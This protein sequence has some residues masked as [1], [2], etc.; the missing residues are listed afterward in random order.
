MSWPC[1]WC[2]CPVDW[3]G[4]PV[5]GEEGQALCY[6]CAEEGEPDWHE[7]M[8]AVEEYRTWCRAQQ[9]EPRVAGGQ[10]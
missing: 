9:Q 2:G 6:E 10:G 8:R 4:N 7:R 3:K 1:E 5:T